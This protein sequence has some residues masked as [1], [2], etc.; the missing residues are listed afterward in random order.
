VLFDRLGRDGGK[1]TLA[2]PTS[3]GGD[4]ATHKHEAATLAVGLEQKAR[5]ISASL[6]ARNGNDRQTR[7]L[8]GWLGF[9]EIDRAAEYAALRA[10]AKA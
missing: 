3:L 9:R 4:G 5:E 10:Q 2:L 1:V 6:D 7:W 8:E